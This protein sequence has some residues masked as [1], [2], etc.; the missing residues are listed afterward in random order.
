MSFVRSRVG[1]TR[2]LLRKATAYF[3]G[4]RK[5]DKGN[6]KEGRSTIIKSL[7]VTSPMVTSHWCLPTGPRVTPDFKALERIETL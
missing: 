6:E 7:L 3:G 2:V 5:S 1:D 4:V